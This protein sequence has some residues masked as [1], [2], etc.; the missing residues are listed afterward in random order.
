MN[1]PKIAT[2]D[3]ADEDSDKDSDDDK[4]KGYKRIWDIV[5][6]QLIHK[7]ENIVIFNLLEVN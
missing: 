4:H 5:G 7:F 6:K 1:N 2:F 3:D